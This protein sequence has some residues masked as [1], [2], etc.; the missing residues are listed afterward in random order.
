MVAAVRRHGAQ[1]RAG[2]AQ[3]PVHDALAAVLCTRAEER[4]PFDAAFEHFFRTHE[5]RTTLA[6]RLRAA[7]FEE[8]EL[9][10][11]WALLAELGDASRVSALLERGPELDALLSVGAA[12]RAALPMHLERIHL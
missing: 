4:A 3:L 5:V 2:V 11:L 6:D 8:R 10:A 7:G 1:R 9:A 12:H